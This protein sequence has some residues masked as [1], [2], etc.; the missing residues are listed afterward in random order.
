MTKEYEEV[1]IELEQEVIDTLTE[2]A[3]Q[4]GI[5]LNEKINNILRE[6]V[7]KYETC[8]KCGL[9]IINYSEENGFHCMNCKYR[10]DET[11]E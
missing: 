9:S 7:L 11:Y 3:E 5:S 2:M 10:W 4:E 6:F 1:E 8:P